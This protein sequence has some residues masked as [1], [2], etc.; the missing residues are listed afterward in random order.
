MCKPHSNSQ[1][2]SL[3]SLH[4]SQENTTQ[5]PPCKSINSNSL[6]VSIYIYIYV[7]VFWSKTIIYYNYYVSVCIYIIYGPA[8]LPTSHPAMFMVYIYILYIYMCILL[9]FKSNIK[10]FCFHSFHCSF[11]FPFVCV[12]V[13]MQF[14]AIF[15]WFCSCFIQFMSFACMFLSFSLL[16][17]LYLLSASLSLQTPH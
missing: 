4:K 1:T 7:C 9:Y 10:C 15:F 11:H 8:F 13:S 2:S 14:P 12:R 5:D 3:I 17:L 6:S 16:Y